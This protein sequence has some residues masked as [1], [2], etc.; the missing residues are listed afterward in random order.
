[1][2]IFSGINLF[3]VT[4]QLLRY[5]DGIFIP[6]VRIIA[7][8]VVFSLAYVASW[9]SMQTKHARALQVAVE[10]A[11]IVFVPLFILTTP[12]S[13]WSCQLL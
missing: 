4:L 13:F 2:F 10:V 1:M 5:Y 11:I 3:F 9:P 8:L 6:V 7:T 12:S